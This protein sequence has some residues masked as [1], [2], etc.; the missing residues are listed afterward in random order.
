[1]MD[2]EVGD[3]NTALVEVQEEPILEVKIEPEPDKQA[4]NVITLNR[5]ERRHRE[6]LLRKRDLKKPP[7][8]VTQI[9]NKPEFKLILND[10]RTLFTFV[11]QLT[12]TL[13]EKGVITIDDLN[14]K[15]NEPAPE[16]QGVSK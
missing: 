7:P 5:K 1:M 16:G 9:Y 11:G 3:T 2:I 10:I 14:A 8:T 13:I 12:N 15:P 4:R 6:K